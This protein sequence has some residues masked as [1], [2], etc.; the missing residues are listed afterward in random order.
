MN[1]NLKISI[2]HFT[3]ALVVILFWL[4][5]CTQTLQPVKGIGMNEQNYLI[6]E[7]YQPELVICPRC[8]NKG[9]NI[10]LGSSSTL[11]FS[12]ILVD[13]EGKWHYNNL[14]KVTDYFQCGVCGERFSK[15]H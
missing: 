3:I 14:N 13:E 6:P 1:K 12:P 8:G 2:I 5:G 10:Y 9:P 15:D 4:S 7:K 11:L